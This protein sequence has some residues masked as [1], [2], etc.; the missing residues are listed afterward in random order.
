MKLNNPMPKPRRAFRRGDPVNRSRLDGLLV[1]NVRADLADLVT[2]RRHEGA[3][4][5]FLDGLGL[6]ARNLVGQQRGGGGRRIRGE[7]ER[8]MA[9][10]VV[11]DL[12]GVE[13]GPRS[14]SGESGLGSKCKS[15]SA[16]AARIS[17]SEM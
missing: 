9:C 15:S 7:S 14:R 8:F 1:H 4:P 12:A 2:I 13:V 6:N 3:L 10:G 17:G 5:L 11:L 16:P